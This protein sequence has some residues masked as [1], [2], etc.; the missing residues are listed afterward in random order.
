M[1]SIQEPLDAR[2]VN[3]ASGQNKES[4]LHS[5]RVDLKVI[6]FNDINVGE[7]AQLAVGPVLPGHLSHH[8]SILICRCFEFDSLNW[9]KLVSWRSP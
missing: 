2:V 7:F 6:K 8:D 3:T 4:W 9:K 1:P 5:K